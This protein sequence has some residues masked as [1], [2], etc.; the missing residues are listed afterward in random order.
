MFS[1]LFFVIFLAVSTVVATPAAFALNV[2]EGYALP[3][4]RDLSQSLAILG[5]LDIMKDDVF[6]EYAQI[7]FCDLYVDKYLNDFEW[8]KIREKIRGRVQ[9]KKDYYRV[10]Y[11]VTA[12]MILGRYDFDQQSFPLIDGSGLDNVGVIVIYDDPSFRYF[13]NDPQKFLKIFPRTYYLSLDRPLT[14]ASLPMPLDEARQ[15]LTELATVELGQG[16]GSGETMIARRVFLR[17]RFRIAGGID[18]SDQAR[19]LFRGAIESIDFFA[20]QEA[21]KLIANIPLKKR[22]LHD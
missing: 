9:E 12:P 6:D 19:A 22:R 4:F 7:M 3:T 10:L 20:D 21:T 8:D 5:G 14:L 16:V 2:G 15:I 13:C 1:R 17:F 11:E 18:A